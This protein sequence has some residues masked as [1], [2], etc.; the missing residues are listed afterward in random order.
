MDRNQASP[1]VTSE[2]GWSAAAPAEACPRRTTAPFVPPPDDRVA[3]E[4][5]WGLDLILDGL[6][7]LRSTG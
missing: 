2:A 5:E 6:E 3:D 4:F 1:V 7:Q